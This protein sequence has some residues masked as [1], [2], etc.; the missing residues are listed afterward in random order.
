MKPK[1][2]LKNIYRSLVRSIFIFILL[3]STTCLLFSN[4]MEFYVNRRETEKAIEMFDG[5]GTMEKWDISAYALEML[6]GEY[7]F[8][9]PRVPLD[10]YPEDSVKLYRTKKILKK[11][12]PDHLG[13]I[14]CIEKCAACIHFSNT[15]MGTEKYPAISLLLTVNIARSGIL[16]STA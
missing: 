3:A 1:L 16:S 15:R 11:Y 14:L 10:Y 4:I 7:I 2:A 12:Q 6:Y 5:I 13:Y 8:A 9:D